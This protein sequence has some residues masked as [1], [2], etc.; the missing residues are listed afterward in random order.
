[1]EDAKGKMTPATSQMFTFSSNLLSPKSM[2][3]WNKIVREQ[4]E[5]KPFVNL[6]GVSLEGPR[7]MSR[8]AFNNCIMFHLL[9]AF[10]INATEQEKYY[11]MNELQKPQ[12]VNVLQF[13]RRVEQLNAHFFQAG[14]VDHHNY[15][16]YSLVIGKSRHLTTTTQP[17]SPST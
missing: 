2:Y 17:F 5:S 9:T 10:P 15:N 4:M 3:S 14:K 16:L 1:M 12:R 11:I 13:V 6:Q 7:G 8:E